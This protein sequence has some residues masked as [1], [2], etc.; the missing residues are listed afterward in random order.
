MSLFET[1][2]V[3]RTRRRFGLGFLALASVSML[4]LVALP[5]PYVIERPGPTFDLLAQTDGQS[6][7]SIEGA[8]VYPTEGEL[9]LLTV[10]IVGNRNATPSW[11]E[12]GMAWLDPSQSVIPIDQVFPANQTVE[13]SEAESTALMEISQQDAIAAALL[14][15]GYEVPGRVYISQVNTGSPASKK[16][17]ASDF[18]VAIDSVKVSTVE[19]LRE[20]VAKYD[21]QKPLTVTV[22]RNGSQFDYEITPVKDDTGAWRLGIIVG[23]KYDFPIQVKLELADVGGPSGGLM[24]ALAVIDKLTPGDLTSKNIIA[25]T[26]TISPTGAVGPI[27]GIQQKMFSAVR[28][29]ATL[30]F[31]P[32]SN[33]DEV[34]GHVPEGLTV[35]AVESLDDSLSA[36]TAVKNQN[37]SSLPTCSA[38]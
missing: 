14:E 35:I 32:K 15:L 11:L 28:E 22:L 20:L 24:F 2:A 18:V 4:G 25:G 29:G 37:L 12:L 26:G 19:Q 9:H 21:G 33:C 13:Q 31:A 3:P 10:S 30:F 34:I 7:I 38:N 27:G 1:E 16:L 8:K 17:V 5:T 23:Y 36:L 6:V